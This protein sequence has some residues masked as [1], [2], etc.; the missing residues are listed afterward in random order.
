MCPTVPTRFHIVANLGVTA[1]EWDFMK[2]IHKAIAGIFA[3]TAMLSGG[4]IAQIRYES[5][6]VYIEV[7]PYRRSE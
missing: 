3:A 4:T 1:Q 5:R 7:Y 6:P 2:P